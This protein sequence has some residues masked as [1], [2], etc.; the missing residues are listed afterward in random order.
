MSRIIDPLL[1]G[2]PPPE[3]VPEPRPELPGFSYLGH[4]VGGLLDASG[5]PV[6]SPVCPRWWSVACGTFTRPPQHG[7]RP[8]LRGPAV[9]AFVMNGRIM[10]I[11]ATEQFWNT[12][13]AFGKHVHRPSGK[14]PVNL[15]LSD[16]VLAG[17]LIEAWFCPLPA[18]PVIEVAG[19]PIDLLA[20]IEAGL[21]ARFAPPW[22]KRTRATE[23]GRR[24]R[25]TT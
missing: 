16:A 17:G 8:E 1:L 2:P 14:N 6:E 20:G 24:A 13:W 12:I 25:R 21:A 22:H 3:Y 7:P 18:D 23:W 11:G 15:A 5:W 9:F 19:M 10:H 4:F